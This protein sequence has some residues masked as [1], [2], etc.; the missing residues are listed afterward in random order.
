M[1]ETQGLK[2]GVIGVCAMKVDNVMLGKMS[3]GQKAFHFI[4]LF[5]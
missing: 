5:I 1:L 4:R 3:R 2:L